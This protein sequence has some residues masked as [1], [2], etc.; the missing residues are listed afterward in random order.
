MEKKLVEVWEDTV[1]IKD[2]LIAMVISLVLGMGCYLI[3]PARPPLPLI[4]SLIGTVIA[5]VVNSVVIKQKRKF[6]IKEVE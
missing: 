1:S 2:L 3:A 6:Q 4:I 5:F